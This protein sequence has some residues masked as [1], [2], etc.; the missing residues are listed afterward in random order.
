MLKRFIRSRRSAAAL[1]LLIAIGVSRADTGAVSESRLISHV[2]FLASGEM[3]GRELCER[4]DALA[5]RYVQSQFERAGLKPPP[6]L[7]DYRQPFT[8]LRSELDRENTCVVVENG[9]ERHTFR[10]DREVLYSHT[11]FSDLAV[12]AEVVFAGFGITAPEY[13]Y[14]DYAGMDVRGSIVLVFNHEPGETGSG[15]FFKGRAPTRY[16]NP[17]VK[18][19]IARDRGAV[20]MIIVSDAA[21]HA[22]D[23]DEL[24][25]RR[26]GSSIEKPYYGL[27]EHGEELP[28][29]YATRPVS[30]ALLE[31]TSIDLLN[32]Q[33][34]IDAGMKPASKRIPGRH[35]ELNVRLK[36][37]E[38]RTAANIVGMIEGADPGLT[39]E[40]IVVAAHHD[41]EGVGE[42]GSVY[43]GADD[44]A[45]GTAGLLETMEAVERAALGRSI[46]FVSLCGEEKGMLGAAYFVKHPPVA[47][48]RAAVNLDMIGR[49]NMNKDENKNMFMVFTSAQT[50]VLEKLVR[51][52]RAGEMDVRVAPYLRFT[53]ASDHMVFH[54]EGIPVVFYFSGFHDDYHTVKDT[55]DK[56]LPGKMAMIVRHLCGLL[57]ALSTVDGAELLFDRSITAEPPK[58]EFERP[59]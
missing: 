37:V 34:G 48:I 24:I 50:P 47:H 1:L 35:V 15:E 4:G 26:R 16:S 43:C 13:G 52:G 17:Q 21:N 27:A 53:G 8:V 41:H 57:P 58:D 25:R 9:A 2:R 46:L 23:I 49:N 59:Y 10:V 44:N 20:G 45:S 56:I 3:E 19:E 29:F 18:A 40:F 38:R 31:G 36:S 30:E 5:E 39:G 32:I 7:A 14:D 28:I 33:K 11:G 55:A 6:G 22:E 51:A 42:G 54:Q 12:R